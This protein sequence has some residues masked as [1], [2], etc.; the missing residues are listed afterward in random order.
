VFK[1]SDMKNGR[2]SKSPI[3]IVRIKPAGGVDFLLSERV[4]QLLAHQIDNPLTQFGSAKIT[5]ISRLADA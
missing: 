4:A 2:P 3:F 1:V 5:S